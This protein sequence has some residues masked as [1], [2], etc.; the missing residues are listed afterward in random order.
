[1]TTIYQLPEPFQVKT[2]LGSGYAIMIEARAHDNMWT[3]ILDNGAIVTFTQDR[4]QATSSYTHRR[5][6]DDET[7]KI[8]LDEA[9][10]KK[11][12]S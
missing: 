1:M 5:G 10:K 4:I 11:P 8:I 2:P 12:R 6:I 3:V 9:T 7:M